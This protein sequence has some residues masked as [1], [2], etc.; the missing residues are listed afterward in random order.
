MKKA[1]LLFKEAAEL[2]H[3]GAMTTLGSMYKHGQ[4]VNISLPSAHHW[5]NKALEHDE[6]GA[7]VA[8]GYC[9]KAGEGVTKDHK[10]AVE[11]WNQA[12]IRGSV[13]AI[14]ALERMGKKPPGDGVRFIPLPGEDAKGEA[15]GE[16]EDGEEEEEE[17][18]EEA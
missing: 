9:Y 14:A 2:G 13:F 15:A 8:L 3:P 4:G 12:A 10:M 11:Y 5:W 7:M 17:E 18:E 6:P 16:L 1:F